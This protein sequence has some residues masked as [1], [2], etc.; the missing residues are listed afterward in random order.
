MTSVAQQ[1][2]LHNALVPLEK[3]VKIGKRNMRINPAKTQKVHTYQVVLDALALTTCY[4]AFFFIADVPEIYMHQF[5]FTIN[6]HDSSYQFKI[7]KKRFTLNM[8]VF[9]EIFQICPRLPNQD[10]DEHPSDE[11]IVSFIKELGHKGNI[12][13]ITDVV[14]DQMHQ[15]YRTFASIINKCLS[16]KIT[17]LDKMRLSRAQILWGMYYKKNVDFVELLWEDFVFQIDNR[18]TKKHEKM[19]Y[20]RFTKADDCVLSTMRFISKSKNF[21]V[22]GALLIEVMTNQKMRNSHAYKTYLAYATRVATPKKARKFKKPASPSKK[23]TLV[24]VKEE[25]PKP[26]KKVDTSIHQA[27]S[28]GDGI[29]SKPG[30]P[31]EPKGDSGDE[32]NVQGDDKDIQDSDDEPQQADDERTDSENQETNDDEEESDDKFAPQLHESA[33]GLPQNKKTSLSHTAPLQ[34]ARVGSNKRYPTTRTTVQVEQTQ[35]QTTC[36]QEESGPEMES[37]QGLYVVQ[38][39]TNATPAIQNATTEVPPFSSSHSVSSNYT[40]AFLNLEN[41]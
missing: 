1:V 24:T 22:Y 8:E 12:K 25:E 2:A 41:L 35:E 30:V 17:G 27:G 16:G 14:V 15:P 26:A 3:R 21:R 18:D 36:I 28:L 39:T 34:G 20:P 38:A 5:W 40:S 31:S 33:G 13:S 19:Y 9:R 37:V 23:R 6:K 29:G 7:G 4:P 11:E 10:F 32:A